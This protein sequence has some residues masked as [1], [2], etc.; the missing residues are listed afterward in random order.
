MSNMFECCEQLESLN[1][2]GW[3][4]S[5]VTDM[6]EMFKGCSNL[7]SLDPSR[8]V[9]SAVVDMSSMFSGCSS[10]TSLDVSGWNTSQ[11]TDMSSLFDECS[12]LATLDVSGWNVSSVTDMSSMFSL[13]K[14]LSRLD[15]SGWNTSTVTD[16]FSMFFACE[17]LASLDISG[18]NTS[19]VTNMC[20]MFQGCSSLTIL[21]LS[22]W[23]TSSV[24]DMGSMFFLCTSL[25]TIVVGEGWSTENA[26]AYEMFSG[27]SSLVG[28]NGTAYSNGHNDAE[29]ARIDAPGTPGYLTSVAQLGPRTLPGPRTY[30]D[31]AHQFSTTGKFVAKPP[32]EIANEFGNFSL[33]T[34]TSFPLPGLEQTNVGGEVC[35]AMVPQGICV[36]DDYILV[37]GY[38]SQEKLHEDLEQKYPHLGGNDTLLAQLIANPTHKAKKAHDSVIWVLDRQTGR[39]LVTLRLTGLVNHVGGIA[40]DGR[41][42]WVATSDSK[43]GGVVQECLIPYSVVGAAVSSG[44]DCY[45]VGSANRLM[46]P[47]KNSEGVLDSASFN[48]YYKGTLW[49]GSWKKTGAGRLVGF[50]GASGGTLKKANEWIIPANANGACF[51]EADNKTWLAVSVSPG[52]HQAS[53]LYIWQVDP[54]QQKRSLSRNNCYMDVTLPPMLEELCIYRETDTHDDVFYAVFESGATIYSC[55]DG[56]SASSTKRA[57]V[58]MDRICVT[59]VA[60]L[61][62][63]QGT[64][65]YREKTSPYRTRIR[66]ACP[67]DVYLEDE[68]GRVVCSIMGGVVDNPAEAEGVSAWA[69]GEDKLFEFPSAS[70]YRVRVVATGKGAM[71]VVV[72]ELDEGV[73]ISERSWDDV[74]IATGDVIEGGVLGGA[75]EPVDE[76][77]WLD[78]PEPDPEPQVQLIPIYRMYNTKTSEH[79]WTKS[80]KEYDSCGKG[81]YRDWRQENVAWYSPNLKA[82]ASYAQSTQGNYVYVWRLYDKGR[83]GDHIY[84][85]YGAEMRQYLSNGW[86]VD[87]GAGFWTMKKGATISGRTTIPIYRAYNP[88]LKRGKHH[89]TPSKSEYDTICKKHGWKPEGVKFYVIKK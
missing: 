1:I 50:S 30:P 83:T 67:V 15:L 77:A 63:G 89:Y 8:W 9:V 42:L 3:N 46:V 74:P 27:C 29:Y 68:D 12:R 4:T 22:N 40:F 60:N 21:D 31:Y 76:R 28:G 82:P 66:V 52:R 81:N 87:K 36:T 44:E 73:T 54:T 43:S 35:D 14:K 10:L 18:W 48:T 72:T 26:Y 78:L 58:F 70:D 13:C 65:T 49:V 5:S 61:F 7:T 88:K 2:S 53:H 51:F 64:V 23:N 19:S 6:S 37:T 25:K 38:C 59:D 69:E 71:D 84:L 80:K 32:S 16:M 86:V 45:P 62:G 47:C 56:A 75:G 24:D 34:G 20:G 39:Y 85:T 57:D 55:V 11:V 79:L 17:S 33:L 41:S